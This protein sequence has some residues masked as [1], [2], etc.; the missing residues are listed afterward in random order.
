MQAFRG[1]F[2][3]RQRPAGYF[4]VK[5]CNRRCRTGRAAIATPAS[6]F[7]RPLASSASAVTCSAMSASAT[8]RSRVS[9]AW[10]PR[11]GSTCVPDASV[12]SANLRS[13]WLLLEVLVQPGERARPRVAGGGWVVAGAHVV[14]ERVPGARLDLDLHRP[15]EL[16]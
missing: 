16:L 7:A 11:R 13:N 10:P 8:T 2:K 5:E 1:G 14:E 3:R 9:T 4:R 15:S 12:I 6:A